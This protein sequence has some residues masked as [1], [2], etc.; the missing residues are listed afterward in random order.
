MSDPSPE[1]KPRNVAPTPCVLAV[2]ERAGRL[3]LVRRAN[4]PDEGLWGFPG[5]RVEP[6]EPLAEAAIRELREETGIDATAEDVL[7]AIDVI[8]R[9]DGGSLADHFVLVAVRCRW[10]AG[11]GEAA[12]DA[13]EARWFALDEIDALGRGAS[14]RVGE[15]ARLALGRSASRE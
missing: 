10:K 15:V 13:L 11:E 12:D 2:V 7:T 14:D 9:D 8:R 1:G 6:G 5:G 4:P 3:L